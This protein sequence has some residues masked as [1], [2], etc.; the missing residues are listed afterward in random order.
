M[1]THRNQMKTLS[2]AFKKFPTSVP[3]IVKCKQTLTTAFVK[4]N[5]PQVINGD[6]S[7]ILLNCTQR[8]S[9]YVTVILYLLI[10]TSIFYSL[11]ALSTD[12]N[13]SLCYIKLSLILGNYNELQLLH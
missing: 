9:E 6:R 3:Y 2:G 10:L 12:T 8:Y 7:I 4:Q 5:G 1:Q 11:G 13:R